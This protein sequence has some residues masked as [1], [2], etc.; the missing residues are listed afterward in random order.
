M[1][2]PPVSQ[3]FNYSFGAVRQAD[4]QVR[5]RLWAPGASQV[6]LE[7]EGT[8]PEAMDA[9][10]NGFYELHRVCAPGSRYWY[11]TGPDQ[12]IPDP[13]SRL[14][15]GDVHDA[16]V[17]VGPCTYAWLNTE[18]RGRPWTETVLYEI[19]V[20]LTG[21]FRGVQE[22]LADLADLGITAIELMPLADFPGT[23]NWGYDGVLPYAPDWAYGTPD[24][25]KLLIDTAHG[26][27]LMVFLDVVYNHF[28]P[29]G[30][31][32]SSYAPDFF[33]DDLQTPWG[34]AIDFRKVPVR[35]FFAENALYW[36]R[37]YRFDGLRLDAVHA[38]SEPDWL[39]EMANF[40]REHIEPERH[41]HLVLENDNNAASLMR[42][43]F[44]AQWNDDA[45]HVLHHILTG[46]TQGYY[47]SYQDDPTGKLARVLSEGFVY[48]GE[49][50]PWRGGAARGE[51]S[52]DLPPCA[53]V[54]F[55][56]NHDQIGNRA[57]G[58][59]LISLC[60]SN[61]DAL[62]AAVAL[63]LL[64]PHIPLLFMGEEVGAKSP[65]LYFT[66]F[67]NPELAQAVREGRRKEFAGFDEFS[68][69]Q[70]RERIPDPN[71]KKTWDHSK[72]KTD[73]QNRQASQWRSWYG[74]LLRLR[75]QFIT[76]NL[77][78]A[79]SDSVQI[80]APLCVVARWRLGDGSLLSLYCNFSPQNIVL[81]PDVTFIAE[82]VIFQSKPR[83]GNQL[84]GSLASASTTA[85]LTKS[86][87]GIDRKE[88]Q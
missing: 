77:A 16:S 63:Q 5:F 80:L 73:T 35:Q 38:I 50:N 66:S 1:T 31:C 67:T 9:V 52:A 27:G 70:A 53:F 21:G 26:M 24:E 75:H 20:G 2:R 81:P 25:L 30:N 61:P 13:A 11:R 41:I 46:E 29:D 36:L 34:P 57:M 85:I 23:R 19:H 60:R 22:K 62:H 33:R 83:S 82:D 44:N 17:V 49:P 69:P 84:N 65:F 10:G 6:E 58:E 4:G 87:N 48:Q 59:R 37:E 74:G 45:H 18:W 12:K 42:Q 3:E 68:D 43:G 40:V 7:L 71:D 76:P 47:T 15:D 56:Q 79:R 8:A 88:V 28:G 51:P 39:P 32:L 55:L 72:V 86:V 14:Q 54:F 78:A 64:T